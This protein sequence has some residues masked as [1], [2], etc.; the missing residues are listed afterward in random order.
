[1]HREGT[2]LLDCCSSEG[3]SLKLEAD[4]DCTKQQ[5]WKVRNHNHG[6]RV[7]QEQMYIKREVRADRG[8]LL[9]VR[10]TYR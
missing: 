3:V 7:G 2:A 6:H 8:P 1:M 9:P 5:E 10:N 4:T